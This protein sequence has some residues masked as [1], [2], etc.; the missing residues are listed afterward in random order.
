MRPLL[1]LWLVGCEADPTEDPIDT[2]TDTTVET[3]DTSVLEAPPASCDGVPLADP[4]PADALE[5]PAGEGVFTVDVPL[6]WTWSSAC[7]A[8]SAPPIYVRVPPGAVSAQLSVLADAAPTWVQ[9]AVDGDELTN[10]APRDNLDIRAQRPA[11]ALSLLWPEMP[12]DPVTAGCWAIFPRAMDTTPDDLDG[13]AV[14]QV[15][16]SA[17]TAGVLKVVP[18]IVGDA[19]ISAEDM[20]AVFAQTLT[21]YSGQGVTVEIAPAEPMDWDIGG[22][23]NITDDRPRML[24]AWTDPNG[25]GAVPVFFV[26]EFSAGLVIGIAGGIPGAP[27]PGTASFGVTVVVEPLLNFPERT[28][29]ADEMG[30]LIQ[31]EL[32]HQLG[33]WHTSEATGE[34]HDMLD[35][36]PECTTAQDLDQSGDVDT[37]ECVGFGAE[38]VM[39][40][41]HGRELQTVV[42]PL[43]ARVIATSPVVQP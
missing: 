39:F 25:T 3:S 33:L 10:L 37:V 7:Q 11:P 42:S 27:I 26:R 20:P 16:R 28:V 23:L 6:T 8:A 40:W 35:D 34:D 1:L 19:P 29:Q 15:R 4:C 43:Q 21:S 5:V 17:P 9:V 14:L 18:V 31:H 2:P 38:N 36:T 13:R 30:S 41:Q 12:T 22:G 24:Q 32:G